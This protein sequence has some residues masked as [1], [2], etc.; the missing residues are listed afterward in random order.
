MLQPRHALA[1][2]QRITDANAAA[3]V[4]ASTRATGAG[5]ALAVDAG[6]DWIELHMAHGYLL[7]S[8]LSPL[9]NFRTDEYGGSLENR[10]RFPLE[11]F[12]A[13]VRAPTD[14]DGA[15]GGLREGEH[16]GRGVHGLKGR[17]GHAADEHR[18]DIM[19]N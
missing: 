13:V 12:D 11:V 9:A 8:F 2:D 4:P 10:M 14:G 18:A 17:S 6:F 7:Q 1:F 19:G 3:I 15:V 5:A 16:I